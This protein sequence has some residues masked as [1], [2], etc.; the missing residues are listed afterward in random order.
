M[1]PSSVVIEEIIESLT[2]SRSLDSGKGQ[3]LLAIEGYTP[4]VLALPAVVG[5][6][7]SS[8]QEG[9]AIVLTI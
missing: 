5:L 2:D 7:S 6:A 4:L 8:V 9:T 3:A 1:P